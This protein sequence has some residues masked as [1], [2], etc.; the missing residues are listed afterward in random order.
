LIELRRDPERRLGASPG[1]RNRGCL[2]TARRRDLEAPARGDDLFG[3][4][5]QRLVNASRCDGFIAD[6]NDEPR[7]DSQQGG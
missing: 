3:R 1:S 7:Y 6:H 2:R 4:L 5:D